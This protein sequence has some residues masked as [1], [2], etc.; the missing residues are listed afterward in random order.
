MSLFWSKSDVF[1]QI[2]QVIDTARNYLVGERSGSGISNHYL[3]FH[4]WHYYHIGVRFLTYRN[5]TGEDQDSECFEYHR[6]SLEY[7][8]TMPRKERVKRNPN[9]GYLRFNGYDIMNATIP[10]PPSGTPPVAVTKHRAFLRFYGNYVIPKV[11]EASHYGYNAEASKR[12]DRLFKNEVGVERL[13][14]FNA[15][16]LELTEFL[17]ELEDRGE[18]FTQD[19]LS[20][21]FHST[22]VY[23]EAEMKHLRFWGREPEALAVQESAVAY[24]AKAAA[25]REAAGREGEADDA[26]KRIRLA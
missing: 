1:Y 26:A 16:F 17:F 24:R 15:F 22:D 20:E 23:V 18:Y 9:F 6:K 8:E 2:T 3:Y 4:L 19:K 10:T 25:K 5:E 13:R 21:W 14:K 7:S 11:I 12:K